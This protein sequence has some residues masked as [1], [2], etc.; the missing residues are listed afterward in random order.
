[1]SELLLPVRHANLRGARAS[2]V[3]PPLEEAWRRRPCDGAGTR[4]AKATLRRDL[5]DGPLKEHV[6]EV[7]LVPLAIAASDHR[8]AAT[9]RGGSEL[10]M[11]KSGRTVFHEMSRVGAPREEPDAVRILR[12]GVDDAR[13]LTLT[14]ERREPVS[15]RVPP[16]GRKAAS[17]TS[18]CM[19]RRRSIDWR[20]PSFL[21]PCLENVDSRGGRAIWRGRRDSCAGACTQTR[22]AR[23]VTFERSSPRPAGCRN[24]SAWPCQKTVKRAFRDQA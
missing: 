21:P 24:P 9:H 16:C 13:D 4:R 11:Q 1:V 8:P 14:Q 19:K 15:D 17:K 5:V 23:V 7:G 20:S 10:G 6:R 3:P 18:S 12:V 2:S 22:K